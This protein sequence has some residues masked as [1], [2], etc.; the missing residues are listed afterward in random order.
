[1]DSDSKQNL[2][3]RLDSK[4]IHKARILA[5]QRGTSISQLVAS[6][7]ERLVAG[8]ERYQS[9][10]ERGLALLRKGLDLGFAP[11]DRDGLHER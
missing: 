11:G 7:I 5:A 10:Q 1:V 9:A 8:D 3:V 6:S 4:V 2:T